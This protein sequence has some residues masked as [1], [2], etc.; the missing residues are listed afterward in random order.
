MKENKKEN[1]CER[2]FKGR[3]LEE[4]PWRVVQQF[5]SEGPMIVSENC[6]TIHL[7]GLSNRF[8]RNSVVC[9]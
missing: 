7:G 8:Y 9:F 1:G 2:N 5:T 3:Y 4:L 6:P